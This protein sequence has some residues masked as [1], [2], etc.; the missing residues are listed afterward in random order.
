MK[1]K[2][3]FLLLFIF[4]LFCITHVHT[5]NTFAQTDKKNRKK[6]QSIINDLDIQI[7]KLMQQAN[8]PGLSIALID[9]AEIVWAKGFGVKDNKTKEPV[10]ENT[11]FEV[12][13]LTKPAFAYA[14]MK[15][16]ENEQ[17]DLDQPLSKYLPEKYIEDDRI[18]QITARKVLSHQTG[19]P[20]WRPRDRELKILFTPGERFSYS[21]EGY[22]YLQAVLDELTAEQVNETLEKLVLKPLGMK[23]SSFI[24]QDSFDSQ[25]ASGHDVAGISIKP[26]KGKM[27]NAAASLRTTAVDYAKFVIAILNEEGLQKFTFAE[28]LTPQVQLDKNCVNCTNRPLGELSQ[29]LGW[30]L[31]WGLQK[32]DDGHSFWH[33]GDNGTFKCYIVANMENKTGVV[34]LTNSQNG[35][36][37]RNEIVTKA[38]GGNQPAFDWVQYEQYDSPEMVF[39]QTVL[40]HGAKTGLKKYTDLKNEKEDPP[41]SEQSI[42]NLGYTLLRLKRIND[43]VE[44]FKLNVY[45]YPESFNVYDSLGESYMV[46]GDTTLAIEYYEK[47]IEIN[48]K[49][50]NGMEM[51]K[52]LRGY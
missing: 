41:V 26:R 37:I 1:N 13:S 30:G 40:N 24:W 7:P 52:K 29:M 39:Q 47:S 23:N 22:V 18:D 35:L 32:T 9:H 28:I 45:E 20:N 49:N 14:I 16:V 6:V 12:G 38:I 51:L 19:F 43:A 8:I 31:G 42:N 50:T 27:V 4:M 21:G 5:G 25:S 46:N 10:T 17:L 33:W 34:Y 15:M 3:S 2:K 48:P 36:A 11:V 44:I